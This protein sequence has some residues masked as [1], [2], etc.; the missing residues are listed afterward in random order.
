MDRILYKNG[1]VTKNE[2]DF[3]C[4]RYTTKADLTFQQ[5]E[6]AYPE[7]MS[8]IDI[9]KPKINL[10]LG[11]L[12]KFDFLNLSLDRAE[13]NKILTALKLKP[14]EIAQLKASELNVIIADFFFLNPQ[15]KQKLA[16]LSGELATQKMIGSLESLGQSVKHIPAGLNLHG[17]KRSTASP[18]KASK[19]LKKQKN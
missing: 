17:K 13:I 10:A 2:K 12:K 14:N 6:L 15:V 7:F 16:A 3:D 19:T 11:Q 8:V 1:E 4:V 5:E 9:F 18:V